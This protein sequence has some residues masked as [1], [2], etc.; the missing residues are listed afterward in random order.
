VV[1]EF[2]RRS[3]S[4]G[5]VPCGSASVNGGSA[6]QGRHRRRRQGEGRGAG[7]GQGH[8]AQGRD[9]ALVAQGLGL[10]AVLLILFWVAAARQG[11]WWCRIG[12]AAARRQ[13]KAR[14]Q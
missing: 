10:A 3:C 11:H 2:H 5:S 4:G 13:E 14:L 1:P 7:E 12:I 6:E 8:G 9:G